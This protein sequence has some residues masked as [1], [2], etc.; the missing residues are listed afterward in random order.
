MLLVQPL[1][2]YE[3]P[4]INL[5]PKAQIPTA[6]QDDKYAAISQSATGTTISDDVNWSLLFSALSVNEFFESTLLWALLCN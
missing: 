2:S 4:A 6:I 1:I 5:T 3:F